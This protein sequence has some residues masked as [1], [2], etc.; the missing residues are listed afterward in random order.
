[1]AGQKD[2]AERSRS[3]ETLAVLAAACIV[4]GLVFGARAFAYA[5]LA[6]LLLGLLFR[7]PAAMLSRVW[8]GF[9]AV[10]GGVNSRILLTVVYCLVLVPIAFLHRRIRGNPMHLER[11]RD[12]QPSYWTIRDHRFEPRDIEQ[13]W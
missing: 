2:D 7:R 11:S 12:P 5:A 4:G 1:M 10:L 13:P 9:A 3:L 8:L 6:L